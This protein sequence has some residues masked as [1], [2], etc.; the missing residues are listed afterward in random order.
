[1]NA[2]LSGDHPL[3]QVTVDPAVFILS[4]HTRYS[5]FKSQLLSQEDIAKSWSCMVMHRAH[6]TCHIVR[7]SSL[8]RHSLL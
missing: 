1:M 2:G 7:A 6:G 5:R 4:D 3:H 8:T